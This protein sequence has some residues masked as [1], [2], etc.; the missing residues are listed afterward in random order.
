MRR[1]DSAVAANE[2]QARERRDAE[3]RTDA[4]AVI[5]RN[6]YAVFVQ[7]F[8]ELSN[9]GTALLVVD[10]YDDNLIAARLFL[11]LRQHRQ[12]LATGS[13]PRSEERHD[14]ELAAIVAHMDLST[15]RILA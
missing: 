6:S 10:G 2:N 12:F 14:H 11:Y 13:A 9:N 8:A 7:R 1:G 3:F 15:A 4:S 5:I